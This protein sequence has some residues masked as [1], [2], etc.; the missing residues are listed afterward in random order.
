MRTMTPKRVEREK[1]N[2]EIVR[3]YNAGEGA[4]VLAAAFGIAENTV[5]VVLRDARRA[6]VVVRDNRARGPSERTREIAR[7][8]QA[9]ESAVALAREYG[10]SRQFV[11]Q[12]GGRRGHT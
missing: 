9:G 7:R 10:V 2:A 3:R 6:G 11:Y 12:V 1:R 8:F 5:G 4:A